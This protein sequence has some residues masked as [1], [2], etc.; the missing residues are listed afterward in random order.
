[1]TAGLPVSRGTWHTGTEQRAM[2]GSLQFV[3]RDAP[4]SDRRE[5]PS[6]GSFPRTE[7]ATDRSNPRS[8]LNPTRTH[9]R[10]SGLPAARWHRAAGSGAVGR[11][12]GPPTLASRQLHCIARASFNGGGHVGPRYW[13]L[14]AVLRSRLPAARQGVQESAKQVPDRQFRDHKN[15]RSEPCVSGEIG[16]A[17]QSPWGEALDLCE[18]L[19]AVLLPAFAA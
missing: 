12:S 14:G 17:Q 4:A 2:S 7:E 18:F 5:P 19:I 3:E 10:Q 9:A 8:A 16:L 15:P 6:S 11:G 13:S 1:M